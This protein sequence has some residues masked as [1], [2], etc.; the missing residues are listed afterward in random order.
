ML[1][2]LTPVRDADWDV[3][4]GTLDWTCR[5][6][7]AHVGHDLLAYAAQLTSRS[8]DA[9]LPLDLVVRPEATPAQTLQ[10][11]TACA[12]LLT[13]AL[14]SAPDEA[15][16]WHWGPTDPSGFAALGV[17]EILV[18]TFDI[19]RPSLYTV[20]LCIRGAAPRPV[21]QAIVASSGAARGSPPVAGPGP[22]PPVRELPACPG[23]SDRPIRADPPGRT[24]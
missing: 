22:C 24:R 5:Q 10:V 17:N 20:D 13:A 16:A 7:A 15:R 4:A 8:A 14:R 19:Y 2:V 3:P 1:R 9:Y 23:G 6:T 18:H 11:V 12:G 21:H